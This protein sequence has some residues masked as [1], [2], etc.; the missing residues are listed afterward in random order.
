MKQLVVCA[1]ALLLSV[2]PLPAHS[3]VLDRAVNLAPGGRLKL[4]A[5]RGSVRL[6]SWDR[7]QVEIH[8]RIEADDSWDTSYARRAVDATTVDVNTTFNNEVGIRSN[9]T[10]VPRE[11]W[12]FGDYARQPSI[13]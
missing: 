4:D 13:H 5:T 3:K 10:N 1:A 11:Y 9:Y 2:T 8:A 6:T 12:I 7:D